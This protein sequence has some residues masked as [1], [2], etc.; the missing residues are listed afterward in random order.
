MKSKIILTFLILLLL[1]GCK[2][3]S[4]NDTN[5]INDN[6]KIETNPIL[7]CKPDNITKYYE[8]EDKTIYLSCL[9]NIYLTN[10]S[11]KLEL[12]NYL[13]QSTKGIDEEIDNITSKLTL[14]ETLYDGGTQIYVD[15]GNITN[16][17]ITIVKCNTISGNKDIYIA[18]KD[19]ILDIYCQN[20]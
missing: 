20:K 11:N 10:E 5:T 1:T 6:F 18:P 17:G 15:N 9:N 8:S 14:E 7:I 16:N 19:S 3:E 12:S 2:R 4:N 13:S